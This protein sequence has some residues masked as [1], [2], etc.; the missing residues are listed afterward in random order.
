MWWKAPKGLST[1]ILCDACGT[2]W[3]KYADLNLVRQSREES[4]PSTK[5]RTNEKREGTPL[6]GPSSKRAKV[7]FFPFPLICALEGTIVIVQFKRHGLY[8]GLTD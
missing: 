6:S 3:R 1:S 2:N 4:L 7:M 8:F 5:S